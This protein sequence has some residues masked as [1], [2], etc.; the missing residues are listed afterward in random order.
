IA[1]TLVLLTE[2]LTAQDT[3]YW[4][5]H[6]GTR[7]T[8]LGGAATAGLGDNAT[9]YYNPA[10]MAFVEDPNLSV[11]VN[12]YKMRAIN[13]SNALGD[14][15]DVKQTQ[16]LT[17]PNLI[18][19]ILK[20]SKWP[21]LSAGYAV[22]TK[23][24][25]NSNFDYLHQA[26]YD[27]DSNGTTENYIASY[28]YNHNVL[29]YW[30][31]GGFSYQLGARWSFGLSHFGIY[32]NVNY[33]NNIDMATLPISDPTQDVSRVSSK[34][35]FNYWSVK[36][37]FKPSLNFNTEAFRWG[38]TY[39]T[40]TFHIMGRA[41]VFREFSASNLQSLSGGDVVFT[42]RREKQK[43]KTK[44]F[45]SLAFGVSM[46]FGSKAWLH[47]TNELYFGAPYYLLFD[48]QNPIN[49]YPSG[50]PED[51]V[52]AFFGNQ[53]FLAYGEKYIPVINSGIG[54]EVRFSDKWD[55]MTGVRTDF[56]HVAPGNQYYTLQK[57]IIESSKWHLTH[58]SIGFGYNTKS[59]KKWTVGLDYSFVPRFQFSQFMNFTS[60]D[61]NNLLQGTRTT[62]AWAR[63]I[64]LK[65]VL[66]I[67]FGGVNSNPM[68]L[69]EKKKN[70][71]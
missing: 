43:V 56:N 62:E 12:A 4:S 57:I 42:D 32:K 38:V 52:L 24:T 11:T 51:Q 34:I 10:A 46:R 30:A 63:Q 20:F 44:D 69:E 35:D 25:F 21:R 23:K 54:Y 3:H 41:N 66:G 61:A 15:L 16:F 59:K 49:T 2:Q 39:T 29:E 55:M 53:N 6:F 8:L 14:G 58:W 28:N 18:A 50:V 40:P 68:H 65:L 47:I 5:E 7:A 9:V 71:E 31:G 22:I 64:S 13:V 60:P 36:G 33:T 37:N 27:V 48:P 45:G 67:E 17:Y 1:L 26:E 19:G 70:I